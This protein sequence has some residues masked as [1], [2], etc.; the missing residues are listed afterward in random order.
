MSNFYDLPDGLLVTEEGGL[1]VI[2]LNRP[3]DLNASTSEMLFA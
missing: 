3:D 2:T 1:R